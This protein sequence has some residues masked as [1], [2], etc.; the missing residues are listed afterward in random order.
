MEATGE[1]VVEPDTTEPSRGAISS[2]LRIPSYRWLIADNAFGGTGFQAITMIQA[3]VVLELTNSD[4]WVG[5]VNGLPAIPA[6]VVVL[7]AGVMADRIERRV[8]LVWARIAMAITGLIMGGLV[9]A[10]VVDAWQLL[11]LAI[12]FTLARVTSV[13][14]SQ[15]L[16]VDIVGRNRLFIGNAVYGSTFN[17]AF[18]VGPAVGGVLI[19]EVGAD[20][21]FL[22]AGA[23]LV[24]AALAAT[25]VRT[26]PRDAPPRQTSVMGD[27]REGFTYVRN[28]PALR[29]LSAMSIILMFTGAYFP[30]VP[31]IARDYLGSGADGYGSILAAQGIGSFAGTVAMLFAGNV[32]SVGLVLLL[33]SLAFFAL[34]AG[35]AYSTTLVMA[36][37]FSFGIGAVIAWWG[38]TMRTAFQI[39]TSDEMRGRVMA[40]FALATQAILFGWFVGGVMSEL[41]GPR[42]TLITSGAITATFYLFVYLKSSAIRQLGRV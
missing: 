37:I 17:L 41:I 19:A 32:R 31:R 14:A 30:M 33:S 3:W 39:P 25:R 35:F 2:I 8:L 21:A 27:L 13:V 10:D 11:L 4:A 1:S 5:A 24:I 15:T 28:D 22:A 6:F 16:V 42:A 36:W 29:W 7:F 34:L 9:A 40:L 23:G 12:V 20:I 26:P 38:N 18:F